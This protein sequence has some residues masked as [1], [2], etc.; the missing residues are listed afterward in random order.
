LLPAP[1]FKRQAINP[2]AKSPKLRWR[3]P[4]PGHSPG[5]NIHRLHLPGPRHFE[6]HGLGNRVDP[7]GVAQ[8]CLFEL[9]ARF[10]SLK[11]SRSERNFSI[12]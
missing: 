6:T 3:G 8:R 12:L 2:E 9:N 7:P 11:A 10:A 4:S 5:R 1:C